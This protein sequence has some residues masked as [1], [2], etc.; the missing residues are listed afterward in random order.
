MSNA[1]PE[2]EAEFLRLLLHHEN[3][4]RA[5]ARCLLP[6]WDAVDD[7]LQDASIVM[8]QKIDQLENSDGFLPWGKVIV[9]FHCLRYCERVP[10]AGAA[11]YL[12]SLPAVLLF[13]RFPTKSAADERNHR[14]CT[15]TTRNRDK[16]ASPP[17]VVVIG[18][19][20]TASSHVFR[21]KVT[22]DKGFIPRSNNHEY[23]EKPT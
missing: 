10:V 4:L 18:C 3:A 14:E 8:W 9:R 1:K 16:T 6:H 13:R 12:L 17:P 5:F 19:R 22:K 21:D 2:S 15:C 23:E 7:V 20:C 11:I